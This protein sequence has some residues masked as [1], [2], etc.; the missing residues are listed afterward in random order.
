MTCQC[1]N[2]NNSYFNILVQATIDNNIA[3]F[4][5]LQLSSI[6]YIINEKVCIIR[7][8][9]MVQFLIGKILKL[10]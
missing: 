3:H 7:S 6:Y 8:Y 9:C 1:H 5:F 4:L 10:S 2:I